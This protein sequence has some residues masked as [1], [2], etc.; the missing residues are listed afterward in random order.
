MYSPVQD[1]LTPEC[2]PPGSI[3]QATGV[4]CIW[5][6]DDDADVRIAIAMLLHSQGWRCRLFSSAEAFLESCRN[7]TADCLV[8]D[9]QMPGMSGAELLETLRRHDLELPAVVITAY[10]EDG[11]ASRSRAAGARAVLGKPFDG[12]QLLAEIRKTFD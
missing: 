5:V 9:L 4:P 12:D 2:A 7:D 6:V 1:L 10:E 3:V 11:L 8:L